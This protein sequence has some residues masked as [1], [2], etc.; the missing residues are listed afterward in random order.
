M[1][2]GA[3]CP[4]GH[5]KIFQGDWPGTEKGCDCLQVKT[6]Y[7]RGV[8]EGKLT[9]GSCNRNSTLCGC[10]NVREV[11][12]SDLWLWPNEV[13]FCAKRDQSLSFQNTHENMF[14]DGT[15]K[16]GFSQCGDS[17]SSKQKGI[18]VPDGTTCPITS[19]KM[20]ST[21]P[22]PSK[23]SEVT[24]T[25]INLYHSNHGSFGNPMVDLLLRENH[26]CLSISERSL[27][28]G[29]TDY[30]LMVNK[31][32]GN[33]TKETRFQ[34]VGHSIGELDLLNA[35]QVS[36]HV[37]PGF[38]TGNQYKW[39]KFSRG[40]VEFDSRCRSL[41]KDLLT[42]DDDLQSIQSK[43]NAL[44]VRKKCLTCFSTESSI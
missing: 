24:G 25:S 3:T 16:T 27:T 37:L 10:K 2:S 35:N 21:S 12:A 4:Q 40:V 8:S 32:D 29:R 28:P 20:A 15:C 43:L 33:C 38:S 23:Y 36:Y 7:R 22:D 1:P 42:M 9:K 17:G 30:Q 13:E 39:K 41:V 5:V 34:E 31:S 19:V 18:C 14:A 44:F 26:V 11:E 6:C